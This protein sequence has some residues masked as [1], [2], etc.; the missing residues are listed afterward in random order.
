MKYTFAF[1]QPGSTASIIEVLSD[2]QRLSP[3]SGPKV[4]HTGDVQVVRPV[5]AI[6]GVAI[7]RGLG[8]VTE[9]F[10]AQKEHASAF[11]ASQYERITVQ[12]ML[13]CTGLLQ[14]QGD[15]GGSM[16]MRNA[17]CVSASTTNMGLYTVT[18]FTFVGSQWT[19]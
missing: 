6:R 2:G 14:I 17:T 13:G 16:K 3:L 15:A 1:T 12:R 4:S 5:R 19:T 7:G 11:A 9:T 10:R 18:D 8:M